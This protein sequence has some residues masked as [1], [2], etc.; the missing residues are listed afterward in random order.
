MSK[1]KSYQFFGT[2][3]DIIDLIKKLPPTPNQV[4]FQTWKEFIIEKAVGRT[5]AREFYHLITKLRIRFDPAKKGAP[6]F[7]GK[8]SL[9]YPKSQ[10]KW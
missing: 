7:E 5:T 6:D 2:L 10:H 3:G 1:N 4:F 8:D 9:A